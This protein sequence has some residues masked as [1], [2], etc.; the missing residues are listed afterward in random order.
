MTYQLL[1]VN[2]SNLTLIII[3]MLVVAVISNN[4]NGYR[5]NTGNRRFA[6][7]YFIFR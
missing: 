5:V 7:L 6:K 2:S 1:H 3:L 4:V